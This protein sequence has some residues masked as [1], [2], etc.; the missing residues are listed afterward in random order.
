MK[1]SGKSVGESVSGAR[2]EL[3]GVG[4]MGVVFFFFVLKIF[5]IIFKI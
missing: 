4:V 5:F 1:A 2:V 3:L